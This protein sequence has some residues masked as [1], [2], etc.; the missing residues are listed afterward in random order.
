[1]HS[2]GLVKLNDLDAKIKSLAIEALC[3]VDGLL[4]SANGKYFANELGH[5][6]YVTGE[7]WMNQ[8]PFRLCL[9]KA[10]MFLE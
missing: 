1:M 5:H 9:N 8:P 4:L 2:T 3:G 10:C 7:M 6:D